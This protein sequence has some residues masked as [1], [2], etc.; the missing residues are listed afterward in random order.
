MGTILEVKYSLKSCLLSVLHKNEVRKLSGKGTSSVICNTRVPDEP[1]P[2]LVLAFKL[3]LKQK[4]NTTSN[5]SK[6]Q[7]KRMT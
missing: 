4:S 5:L 1:R 3:F 2:F 6:P 7:A